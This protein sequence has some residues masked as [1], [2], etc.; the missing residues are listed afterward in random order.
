MG[1]LQGLHRVILAGCRLTQQLRKVVRFIQ[2]TRLSPVL[3]A[4][5]DAASTRKAGR[6][7]SFSW[8][9]QPLPD[10]AF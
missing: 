1:E 2:E 6:P 8:R 3:I 10:I 4:K 5:T 9:A 7:A